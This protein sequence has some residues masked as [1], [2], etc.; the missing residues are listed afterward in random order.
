MLTPDRTVRVPTHRRLFR[1]IAVRCTGPGGYYNLGNALGLVSGV[2]FQI[3]AAQD[4]TGGSALA[5]I[6]EY[7]VGSTGATALTV[8]MVMFFVSGELYHRAWSAGTTPDAVMVRRAD[9]LSG[10]AA[11]VL[12][13]ALILFGS[14]WLAAVST[15]LLAGGKIG[16]GLTPGRGWPVRIPLPGYGTTRHRQ[17]DVFRFSALLSRAP[18][19]AAILLELARLSAGG[20]GGALDLAQ[21]GVLL[22]CYMLWC[23][24]DLLLFRH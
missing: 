13:I 7:L 12:G 1:A 18:A 17:I 10:I 6:R 15:L 23:R 11:F 3:L 4:A 9:F 22:I 16:N 20:E 19:V 8:A 14:F 24:A 21:S 2:A 5:A